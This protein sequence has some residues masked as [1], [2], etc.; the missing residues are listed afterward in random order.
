MKHALKVQFISRDLPVEGGGGTSV[1]RLSLL[2]YLHKI[3]CEIEYL[4]LHYKGEDNTP[5]K[6]N[7]YAFSSL[8]K[9]VRMQK[10]NWE[11]YP[12]WSDM[13]TKKEVDFLSAQIK[14]GKPNLLIVDHSWL[15][16]LLTNQIKRKNLVTAVLTHDVQYKKIKEF[17][18]YG[19]NPYK[20]NGIYKQPYWDRKLEKNLL[21]NADIILAIQKE[22]CKT[23]QKMLSSK[24]IVYL[25][26]AVEVTKNDEE[27]QVKGRCL[28]VGGSAQHNAFGL[29]WFLSEVWP[30]VIAQNQSAT[31]HIC[32]EVYKEMPTADYRNDLSIIF[33]G[34]VENLF[35][36]Y[37]EAQVCIIPMKVGSGL[38]IKLVEA[39]AYAKAC[40][41]TSIGIEGI[42]EVANFGV[43]VADEKVEFANSISE[44][45]KNACMK[46]VYEVMNK[47]YVKTYLTPDAAYGPFILSV[48]NKMK[49]KKFLNE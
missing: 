26:M 2:Q 7:V 25:P 37:N 17:K 8:F 35:Q 28:F 3:G 15:S 6:D 18:K 36:E 34:K 44:L 5:I 27:K 42:E 30:I 48:F 11:Q 31:L 4:L 46:S 40:V 14:R 38:K 12:I 20:R 22:D 10:A 45:L 1:Y 39:M 41:S 23:F 9:V 32:G 43:T 13:P 19:V 33:K 49:K 29:R 47:Q 24:Q 21:S 16:G